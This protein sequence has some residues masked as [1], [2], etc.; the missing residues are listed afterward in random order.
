MMTVSPAFGAACAQWYDE[1]IAWLY[2]SR[3]SNIN[4]PHHIMLACPVYGPAFAEMFCSYSIPSIVAEKNARALQRRCTLVVFT[5]K[6]TFRLIMSG[7]HALSKYNIEFIP[8]II[9]DYVMEKINHDIMN[10]MWVL[11][12]VHSIA[13]QMCVRWGMG[14]SMTVPDVTYSRDYFYNL[15]PLQNDHDVI[16]QST[17]TADLDGFYRGLDKSYRMDSGA[18]SIDARDMGML[19]YKHLH[20]QNK[21]YICNNASFPDLMPYTQFQ[22]WRMFDTIEIYTGFSNPVWLS[23][24]QCAKVA[25][26]SLS[27]LDTRIPQLRVD[28]FYVPTLDD[29]MHLVDV[30]GPDKAANAPLSNR[31]DWIDGAW[32]RLSY[33]PAFMPYRKVPHTVYIGVHGDGYVAPSYVEKMQAKIDDLLLAERANSMFRRING[34]YIVPALAPWPIHVLP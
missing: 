29:D 26:S 24:A 2:G 11:G 4:G 32:E 14:F 27:T 6:P 34:K 3:V 21:Q 12:L 13:M 1:E 18:I 5:D 8:R 25:S 19:G 22:M 33:N 23:H 10:R 16:L 15:Y 31:D 20:Q 7:C 28:K 30:S 17:I 9:P